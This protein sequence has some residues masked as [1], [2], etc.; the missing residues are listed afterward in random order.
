MNCRWP[1]GGVWRRDVP[2]A[3]GRAFESGRDA[4]VSDRVEMN[5]EAFGVEPARLLQPCLLDGEPAAMGSACPWRSQVGAA[6][7]G[8]ERFA[9]PSGISFT[10]VAR[11]GSLPLP[12]DGR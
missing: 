1:G 9:M 4:S 5:L 3:G 12:R 10:V 2:A 7:S 11:K 8:G 6:D